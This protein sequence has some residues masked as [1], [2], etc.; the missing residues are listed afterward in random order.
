MG[1]L[2]LYGERGRGGV[3]Q[4]WAPRS[5]R[6]VK[7][8][9]DTS[10]IDL[11]SM[12]KPHWRPQDHRGGTS[13]TPSTHTQA[14]YH[15][16][17]RLGGQAIKRQ[18]AEKTT[19]GSMAPSASQSYR[20]TVCETRQPGGGSKM[21]NKQTERKQEEV[22][23]MPG[24]NAWRQGAQGNLGGGREKGT[25]DISGRRKWYPNFNRTD[26]SDWVSAV[27]VLEP[28]TTQWW[29]SYLVMKAESKKRKKEYFEQFG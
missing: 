23:E 2:R 14:K 21:N 28:N 4:R 22:G 19:R 20:R 25:M 26:L 16:P 6:G 1:Q 17:Q 8:A 29:A 12:V 11:V 18:D 10:S 13:P 9:E 7:S 27:L 5:S 3:R 24:Q 15:Q